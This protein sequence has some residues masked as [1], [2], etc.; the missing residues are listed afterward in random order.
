MSGK[1]VLVIDDEE[2]WGKIIS[3][4]LTQR[5]GY[6][7]FT[8]TTAR[9]GL[10]LARKH[11]PNLVILDLMLPDMDGWRVC[12]H[13]KKEPD[14]KDVPVLMLSALVDDQA[15]KSSVE[16]GDAYL[17]KPF[18]MKVMIEKVKGLLKDPA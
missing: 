16:L 14:L 8:A 3:Q 1:T 4:V 2:E 9:E 10:A 15:G 11:K 7:V 13:L 6:E 17:S 18:D 12:Q 5:G